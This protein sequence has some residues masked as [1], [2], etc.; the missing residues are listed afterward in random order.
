MLHA[1]AYIHNEKTRL[2]EL[3]L[4]IA[5][6]IAKRSNREDVTLVN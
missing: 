4:A 2:H 3:L 5:Q 1:K 6:E